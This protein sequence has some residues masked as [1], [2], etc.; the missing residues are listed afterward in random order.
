MSDTTLTTL[1]TY[2]LLSAAKRSFDKG[3]EGNDVMD[4]TAL[5]DTMEG[6]G[7]HDTLR[8]FAGVDRLDGGEG[9]DMLDGGDDA[10]VLLDLAGDNTL[11]GGAG[12]D[13]LTSKSPGKSLLSGGEGDDYFT[14]GRGDDTVLGGAGDDYID[15]NTGIL[16]GRVESVANTVLV[17]AGEGRD[18]IVIALANTRA[19]TVRVT[20]GAGRDTFVVGAPVGNGSLTINDFAPGNG[21]DLIDLSQLFNAWVIDNPFGEAGLFQ[22]LQRGADTVIQ[23][24]RDGPAGGAQ[25]VDA[26]TLA[27]LTASSLLA[28]NF[29]RDYQWNKDP[30][31]LTI[32][33]GAGHDRLVGGFGPDSI[34]GGAGFDTMIG[35]D[36]ADYLDGESGDDTLQGGNGNDTVLGGAGR[37]VLL[38]GAG[39]DKLSGGDD[40]DL[41]AG[42]G[43]DDTLEGGLGNDRLDGQEGNDLLSGGAGEDTLVDSAGDNN[44]S[45]GDG[46]DLL[47]SSGPGTNVLDGGTGHDKLYAGGGADTLRGGVGND[48][49]VADTRVGTSGDPF[50]TRAI[51]LEGGEGDDVFSVTAGFYEGRN[52]IDASGGVGRDT[53]AL[54]S[55]YENVYTIT[56][57]QAGPQGDLLSIEALFRWYPGGPYISPGNPFATGQLRLLQNGADAILQFGS[58][59]PQ[60]VVTLK[61]V[62]ASKLVTDN[63]L[64]GISPDGS[65]TGLTLVGHVLNNTMQ[66]GYTNDTI[67]GLAGNDYIRGWDG[68]DRIDGGDGDD[69]LVGGV[70]NDVVTGG[71]GTDIAQFEARRADYTITKTAH[72]MTVT[73]IPD[74]WFRLEG[75]DTLSGIERLAFYGTERLAFDTDGVGGQ[76]YRLYQAAFDRSPDPFGIGFW[77]AHA[78]R[79]LTLKEVSASFVASP[80]FTSLYG[81]APSTA[82]L[83][84]RFYENILDRKPDPVGFA[85]WNDVLDR[86]LITVPE[87]LAQF[88]ESA[89]NQAALNGV[90]GQ[91][92]EYSFYWL[93]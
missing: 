54:S 35:H 14:A 76:V 80:E 71:A 74:S 24:D 36:G 42:D 66:G 4:G 2:S 82:E 69:F 68:D 40:A 37:D 83:V 64:Q 52:T 19:S 55:M 5:P 73:A 10:D 12:A 48:T 18:Y 63:F 84:G 38:G 23:F 21:G 22:V 46:D 62:E 43:G 30:T 78:D 93:A 16:Y 89:E 32:T 7:G 29:V 47:Q 9:N 70:G 92:F 65:L 25:F 59:L 26:I 61:N 11:L 86:K 56:D 28:A 1:P 75:T 50:V 15:I 51:V 31:P 39:N 72:G 33:G 57:F 17:D 20:G 79:G 85:F 49:L 27:G 67:S 41:L 53:F 91:G 77:M 87:L 81:A 3:T 13:S 6:L 88:S 45:G 44:F 34:H 60:T 90:I 8:G 58:T